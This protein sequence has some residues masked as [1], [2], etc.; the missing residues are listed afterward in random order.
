MT[1]IILSISS[2]RRDFL[3]RYAEV[4]ELRSQLSKLAVAEE[5]AD[6]AE[7]RAKVCRTLSP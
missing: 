6:A 7:L 4:E 3:E 2:L 1:V 5:E